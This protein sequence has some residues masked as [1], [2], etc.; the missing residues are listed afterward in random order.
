[1]GWTNPEDKYYR[2]YITRRPPVIGVTALHSRRL[3]HRR[4]SVKRQHHL[5][6]GLGPVLEELAALPSVKSIIPGRINSATRGSAVKLFW[7]Y[8]TGTG[9]KLLAKARGGV[10]EIFVVTSNAAAVRTFLAD[11]D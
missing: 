5:L 10:Q 6:Q 2:E 4:H 9:V 8:E 1:M 3:K 11:H 7:K